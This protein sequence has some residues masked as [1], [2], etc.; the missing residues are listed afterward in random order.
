VNA[1]TTGGDFVVSDA[2]LPGT[3]Q[4]ALGTFANMSFAENL[5]AGTLADGF[6]ALG[7]PGSLGNYYYELK[8]SL[9]DATAAVPEPATLSLTGLGVLGAVARFRRRHISR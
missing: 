5:G 3:Y 6:I 1:Y 7:E 4:V 8:V 9:P 2:L